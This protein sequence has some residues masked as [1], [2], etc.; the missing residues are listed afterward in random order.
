[1]SP[2]A[3][4][5]VCGGLVGLGLA[6][7]VRA[8]MVPVPALGDALDALSGRTRPAPV[9]AESDTWLRWTGKPGRL[10]ISRLA[11]GPVVLPTIEL[12]LTGQTPEAFLIRKGVLALAGL[13]LLPLVTAILSVGGIVLPIAV[14]AVGGIALALGGWFLPNLTLR[15][16]AEK[17]RAGMRRALCSY[18][19]L[20]SLRRDASEGPTQALEL[21]AAVGEGWEFRRI[22]AA[23][24]EARVNNLQPW[25]GLRSLGERT[26]VRELTDIADIATTA[27]VDGASIVET[28]RARAASLRSQLLTDDQ[29]SANAESEKM[30]APVALLS[31]L[32]LLLFL[33]PALIRLIG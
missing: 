21:A 3:L 29:A 5:A 8:F 1:M 11:R 30:S 26:A 33:Y 32:F 19:D 10:I 28:L 12:E 15:E 24:T 22:R 14:P 25:D 17:A 2:Y 27:A 13:V 7:A 16:E 4:L 9:V 18:L 20:V 6:M 23:L 31:I